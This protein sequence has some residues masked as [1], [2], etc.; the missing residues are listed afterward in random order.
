MKVLIT[1][2]TEYERLGF[3]FEGMEVIYNFAMLRHIGSDWMP[4]TIP[5]WVT[6]LN[7]SADSIIQPFLE[8]HDITADEFL[9]S[10]NII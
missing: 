9:I 8:I 1:V 2:D 6:L 4:K 5:D 10:Y 3:S 7:H